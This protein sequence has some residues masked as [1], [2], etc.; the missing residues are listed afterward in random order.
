MQP[1]IAAIADDIPNPSSF[2]FAT[3]IPAAAAARSLAR[4]AK[5]R[6]PI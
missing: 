2:I 5:N 1:A 6:L 4:I 3:F